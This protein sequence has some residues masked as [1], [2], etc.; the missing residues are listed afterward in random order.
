MENSENKLPLYRRLDPPKET[1]A[2]TV[3]NNIGNGMMLGALPFMAVEMYS[4]IAGKEFSPSTFRRLSI[5]N[6]AMLVTGCGLGAWYGMNEA[7]RLQDY[8]TTVSD[9]IVRLSEELKTTNAKLDSWVEKAQAFTHHS[10][11]PSR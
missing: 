8:R 7:K 4:H 3:L 9:E 1:A 2:T 6:A 10:A 11:E 5:A